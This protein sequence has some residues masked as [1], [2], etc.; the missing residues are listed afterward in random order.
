MVNLDDLIKANRDN[1]YKLLALIG[2]SPAK[3]N[4]IIDYLENRNWKLC[5]VEELVLEAIENVPED[6][7]DT[8]LASEIKE[9][10]LPFGD[11]IVLTNID[12][13]YSPEVHKIQPIS[14]FSYYARGS[15]EIIMFLRKAR[16]RENKAIYSFPNKDDHREMDLSKIIYERLDNVIV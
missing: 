2:D 3:E 8:M 15:T 5:N 11:K 1:H 4:K 9:K 7:R 13:L 12:I 16:L 10:L 14:F 6:M